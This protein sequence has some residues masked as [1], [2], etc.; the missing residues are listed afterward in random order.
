MLSPLMSNNEHNVKHK[1]EEIPTEQ[2]TLP[3]DKAFRLKS[4]PF[5]TRRESHSVVGVQDV[6]GNIY[7]YCCCCFEAS[8]IISVF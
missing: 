2:R 8:L 1:H 3:P 5:R 4:Q 6:N 7:L